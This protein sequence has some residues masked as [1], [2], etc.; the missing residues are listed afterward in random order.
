[1]FDNIKKKSK[2]G[3]SIQEMISGEQYVIK[4]ENKKGRIT[5]DKGDGLFLFC[6]GMNFYH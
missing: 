3:A 5:G 2:Q 1:L 6:G 4:R